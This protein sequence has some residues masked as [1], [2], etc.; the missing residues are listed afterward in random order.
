M[1]ISVIEKESQNAVR[2]AKDMKIL[3][4]KDEE[5]AIEFCK[6]IKRSKGYVGEEYDRGVKDSYDLYKSL[7]DK[8]KKYLDLL[9]E[10]E[11]VIKTTIKSYRLRLEKNRQEEETRQKSIL[12]AQVKSEQDQLMARAEEAKI[13]GD[14]RTADIL[15][16][17]STLI[18]AGGVHIESKAVKQ[19]GMSSSIVWKGR[20]NCLKDLPVEFTNISANQ[21]A[22]DLHIK[23]NGKNKPIS[24][25]EYYQDVD[26]RVRK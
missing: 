5:D 21:K 1:E 16:V 18:E 10:A 23:C 9:D 20:V 6:I 8:R 14:D 4:N 2:I 15:A 17:E 22:I 3:N 26:L 11:D 12:D 24:G 25:V 19:D 13:K 7:F